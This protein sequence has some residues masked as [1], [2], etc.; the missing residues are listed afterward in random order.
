M[1]SFAQF[2][3]LRWRHLLRLVAQVA[4]RQDKQTVND[5]FDSFVVQI[6][7]DFSQSD[8]ECECDAAMSLCF[9]SCMSANSVEINFMSRLIQFS[10]KHVCLS[11]SMCVCVLSLS[12]CLLPLLWHLIEC[13]KYFRAALRPCSVWAS[14]LWRFCFCFHRQVTN[15][16]VKQTLQPKD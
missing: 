1:P 16:E 14:A 11:A 10:I 15:S 2:V 9:S 12:V 8:C 3:Q 4:R 5:S 6:A 13:I 7:D